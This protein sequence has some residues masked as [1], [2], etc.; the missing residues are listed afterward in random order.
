M[1]WTELMDSQQQLDE[2][3]RSRRTASA[4]LVVSTNHAHSTDITIEVPDETPKPP[5][6]TP[7]L[8]APGDLESPLSPPSASS[9]PSQSATFPSRTRSATIASPLRS[10]LDA[11]DE[12]KPSSI[13]P[14]RVR[15]ATLSSPPTTARTNLQK[16]K[17]SRVTP[18]QLAHLERVFAQDR[19]P[20][21]A[22]RKEI[23]EQLGMQERQTQIWFQNRRAKAK[24]VESKGRRPGS[25][26]S[27]RDT[28]PDTPPE[29]SP[30]FE[31]EL[32]AL[33]HETDPISIIP[34]T[35]LTIGSW[36]RI[37]DRTGRHDLVAYIS[38]HRASLTWFIHSGGHGFKMEIPI[39]SVVN[40]EF[41]QSAQTHP[42]HGI[43]TF[44]LSEK[45]IFYMEDAANGN[46]WQVCD[47]WT[48]GRQASQVMK[49][50]LPVVK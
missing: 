26:G 11:D 29:L 23:S 27:G 49:H 40:T 50:Q 32:Q 10:T 7:H 22:R 21:A 28:P 4:Q 12:Q 17:R 18:E 31:G 9:T 48:E 8:P 15:S 2:P 39:S 5:S 14:Q 19:S 24:L 20:T 35:D 34:C 16:R 47:D 6:P 30:G 43:A 13:G 33:L 42:G 38:E 45:P 25:P 41:T 1:A 3:R 37:A 44:W 46:T 36:H